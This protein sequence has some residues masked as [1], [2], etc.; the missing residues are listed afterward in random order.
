MWEGPKEG[1]NLESVGGEVDI[2]VAMDER[3]GHKFCQY[4]NAGR[5]GQ[6][7]YRNCA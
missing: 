3:A 1:V 7:T 2:E 4:Q 6:D 5:Q